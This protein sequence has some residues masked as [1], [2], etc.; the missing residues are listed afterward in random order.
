MQ[1]KGASLL[2]GVA[3]R[4]AWKKLGHVWTVLTFCNRQEMVQSNCTKEEG[5][6]KSTNLMQC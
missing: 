6:K 1:E 5:E 3:V 4:N 2:R